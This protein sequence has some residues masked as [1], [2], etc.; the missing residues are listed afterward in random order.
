MR[1]LKMSLNLLTKLDLKWLFDLI[2]ETSA[3]EASLIIFCWFCKANLLGGMILLLAW[4]LSTPALIEN[5]P[6]ACGLILIC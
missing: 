5:F 1:I 2:S 6:W 3:F 4:I